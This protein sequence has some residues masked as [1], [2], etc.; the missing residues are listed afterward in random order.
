MESQVRKFSLLF[1]RFFAYVIDSLIIILILI[2]SHKHFFKILVL[3]EFSVV[4]TSLI[5]YELYFF[6][7]E[8][9]LKATPGKLFFGLRVKGISKIS[10]SSSLKGFI[11][12]ILQLFIRNFSRILIFIPPLFLWN[13]ILVLM[14]Y[15]GKSFSEVITNL[16][17]EFK[18]S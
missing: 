5:Y 1:S 15:G 9:I 18:N 10:F 8:L 13:E 12:F 14:Y 2:L 3:N 7:F 4:I 11:E 6:L 16:K 17:V